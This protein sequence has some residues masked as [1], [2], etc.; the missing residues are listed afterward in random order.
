MFNKINTGILKLIK[1]VCILLYIIDYIKITP[2]YGRSV[3]KNEIRKRE[4]GKNTMNNIFYIKSPLKKNKWF[5]IKE[6]WTKKI[7]SK[8]ALNT[9]KRYKEALAIKKYRMTGTSTVARHY[10][11]EGRNGGRKKINKVTM[12]PRKEIILPA[13]RCMVL[14]KMDN[15]NARKISKSGIKTHRIQ[16][17]NLLRKRIYFEKEDRFVKLRV[18]TQGLKTIKKF[19][20]EYCCEK[21]KLNLKKKKVDAGRSTRKKKKKAKLSEHQKE[22]LQDK[23]VENYE[24][25]EK[26]M[27]NLNI[28]KKGK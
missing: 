20:L 5:E 18:S 26:I 15:R 6:I 16:R 2:L 8:F 17:V 1:N 21:F 12:L 23:S 27:Q 4:Y 3:D 11:L 19:G 22:L 24:D 13:R 14:G 25:V 7:I 28:Q 10:G 9:R